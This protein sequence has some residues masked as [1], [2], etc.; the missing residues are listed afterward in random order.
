M[1]KALIE[2]LGV[3]YCFLAIFLFILLASEVFNLAATVAE[4]LA[5]SQ[6]GLVQQVDEASGKVIWVKP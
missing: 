2:E 3:I 4:T 5:A 1:I 6:A